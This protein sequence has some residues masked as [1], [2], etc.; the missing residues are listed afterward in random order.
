VFQ[1]KGG[2][3]RG[4]Q[5]AKIRLRDA[6][7]GKVDAEKERKVLAKF[8]GW[9][10][11]GF[12]RIINQKGGEEARGG[13]TGGGSLS[14]NG[15][16]VT[17]ESFP[18]HARGGSWGGKRGVGGLLPYLN[19]TKE[20]PGDHLERGGKELIGWGRK[21]NFSLSTEKETTTTDAE[22]GE[23]GYLR[24]KGGPNFVKEEGV[25]KF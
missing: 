22:G 8:R 2:R 24:K 5:G 11:E 16:G 14:K 25:R 20:D 12:G 17:F 7:G 18:N 19:L 23:K 1:L 10:K 15:R 4:H 6:E 13:Q 3:K 21:N 9:Q